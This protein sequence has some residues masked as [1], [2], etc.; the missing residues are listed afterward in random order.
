MRLSAFGLVIW[1]LALLARVAAPLIVPV[2]V[3]EARLAD[4]LA[5][6]IICTHDGGTATPLGDPGD[7]A[8]DHDHCSLFCCQIAPALD[9]PPLAFALAV[10]TPIAISLPAPVDAPAVL[11]IVAA[12]RARGPPPIS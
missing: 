3:A 1:T 6:A 10:R 4:P 2:S 11:S 5:G 7:T 8:S 12:H 9:A